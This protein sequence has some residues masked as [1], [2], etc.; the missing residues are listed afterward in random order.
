MQVLILA[1]GLG[2]RLRAV[3]SDRPKPMADVGDRP[4]LEYLIKQVHDQGFGE[5]VL[6]TGYM[7]DRIRDYFGDGSQWQVSI[8]H[9]VETERLGTAGAIKH[10][11]SLI[12][13]TC[14]VMNGDSFVD[15]DFQGL[16]AA[17]RAQRAANSRTIGTLLTVHMAHAAAYGTL[18]LD[19]QS[20]VQRFCEKA[21]SASGWINAGVYVLEPLILEQIPAGRA[22]S[23]EKET[24]PA[25]LAQGWHLFGQRTRGF[26]VDIGTPDG[27][28]CFQQYIKESSA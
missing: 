24:F 3:V 11:Q 8:R 16:V 4:F 2:K 10:A 5:L 22:V 25:V 23:I 20:H 17:H 21:S 6:C 28:R 14:I 9:S 1:G 18:A 7:A 27:Y 15:A 12:D 26:F 19:E 13:G